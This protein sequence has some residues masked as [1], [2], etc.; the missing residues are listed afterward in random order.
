MKI[1]FYHLVMDTFKC[2]LMHIILEF[3]LLQI[4]HV[5]N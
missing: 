4:V 3:F 2:F 5:E 1:Q